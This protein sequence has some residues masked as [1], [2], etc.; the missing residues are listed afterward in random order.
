MVEQLQ[1]D[2]VYEDPAP[3]SQGRIHEGTIYLA[4]QVP[5]N[6]DGEIVG[7][8]IETQTKQAVDNVEALLSEADSSLASVVS[9]T[10][11]LIDMDDF[12]AFNDV[13][14][15]LFPDPKPARTTVAV[16]GLAVDARLELQVTAVVE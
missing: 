4:G 15:E 9:V 5:D 6:S 1:C 12:E 8:D 13:Y 3:Y 16:D 2:R 11:Y 14:A 10:A 7:N